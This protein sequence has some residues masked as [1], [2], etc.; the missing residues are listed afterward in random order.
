[1]PAGISVPLFLKCNSL[2]H[3]KAQAEAI[4]NRPTQKKARRFTRRF[5]RCKDPASAPAG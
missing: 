2:N 1:M 3:G 5:Y 4:S